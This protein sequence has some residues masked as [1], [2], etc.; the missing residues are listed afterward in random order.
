MSPNFPVR[1]YVRGVTYVPKKN[2]RQGPRSPPQVQKVGGTP[3]E[4][5]IMDFT[6]MPQALGCKYLL[7][8]I[9]SQDG[10]K[11]SLHGL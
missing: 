11:P 6:E 9:P 5:L 1:Q 3:L 8:F 4:N 7:V 2:P 10:W